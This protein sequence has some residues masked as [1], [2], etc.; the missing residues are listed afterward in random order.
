[1]ERYIGGL[2]YNPSHI[3]DMAKSSKVK[4]EAVDSY[5]NSI[6]GM[7]PSQAAGS[8]PT[9]PRSPRG[10]LA[11][12]AGSEKG[13]GLDDLN[14]T[15][16]MLNQAPGG[17]QYGQSRD[18]Q[19]VT[20]QGE[21][22][23]LKSQLSRTEGD[24]RRMQSEMAEFK[25]EFQD[26]LAKLNSS[27]RDRAKAERGE[28]KGGLQHRE[29][30]EH[31]IEEW[32]HELFGGA[33]GE[34]NY[35][36]GNDLKYM[37]AANVSQGTVETMR[38]GLDVLPG[39]GTHDNRQPV[40]SHTH[41]YV[42]DPIGASERGV[43]GAAGGGGR[44]ALQKDLAE[45]GIVSG[46]EGAAG[47]GRGTDMASDG[48]ATG[49]NGKSSNTGYERNGYISYGGGDG[50]RQ[51]EYGYNG[52]DGYG[53]NGRRD[54]NRE[55]NSWGQREYGDA[56]EGGGSR[57]RGYGGSGARDGYDSYGGGGRGSRDGNVTRG[58][59]SKHGGG[60]GGGGGKFSRT[61]RG[62]SSS[63]EEEAAPTVAAD[64]VATADLSDDEEIDQVTDPDLEKLLNGMGVAMDDSDSD[65]GI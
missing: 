19:G 39:S 23:F 16:K 34:A 28:P 53:E 29:E 41:G 51:D 12:L 14:D 2:G 18:P 59:Q 49:G 43:A 25:L 7:K 46:R 21:V 40:G 11:T 32:V 17:E 20:L 13:W 50:Y 64:G 36:G 3:S 5:L 8:K 4:D 52:Q 60:G 57:D 33:G 47:G 56:G 38:Q 9:S 22:A 10:H 63:S 45:Y 24:N 65:D 1:L 54:G 48:R 35:A 31:R 62:S 44:G 30:A 6:I 55:G 37:S 61:R 26:L 15:M 58:H 42:G 27:Y